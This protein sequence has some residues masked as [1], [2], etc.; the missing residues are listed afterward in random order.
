MTKPTFWGRCDKKCLIV[1]RKVHTKAFLGTVPGKTSHRPRD[2]R[3]S[4]GKTV[5]FP[6]E[7]GKKANSSGKTGE[8]PNE[9]GAGGLAVTRH[10]LPVPRHRAADNSPAEG[11]DKD[12]HQG[13]DDVEEAEWGVGKGG[14]RQDCR[15]GHSA[16][17]PGEKRRGHRSGILNAAAKEPPL[18]AALLERKLG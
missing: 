3:N 1:P 10:V 7:P 2:N 4:S 18:V 16:A 12:R 11:G 14:H 9:P 13:R 6:D 15:L 17:G 8:H 5:T